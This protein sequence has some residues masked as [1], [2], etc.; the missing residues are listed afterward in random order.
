LIEEPE[1]HLHA[2]RQLKIM[3]FLQNQSENKGLQILI[4]THSPN[5]ASAIKLNNLVIVKNG[6]AY[7]LTEELTKL[8]KSDYEFLERFLD[9]TK[10]NLF[11]A[12]GLMIV[13]GDA[14]NLLIPTLASLLNL[15][16]TDNGVS[17]VN[18]GGVGLSRYAR[19]FQ[20]IDEDNPLDI[21][22]ACVTDSDVMPN[23]AI[24]ILGLSKE[25]EDWHQIPNRK[26]RVL[27]D[28]GEDHLL[29]DYLKAKREKVTGQ[30]VRSFLSNN[31]TFEYDLILGQVDEN[32][33]YKMGLAKDVFTAI[34]LAKNDEK[35][36][37]GSKKIEDVQDEIESEFNLLVAEK[38]P[39]NTSTKEEVIA[40]EIY[41]PLKNKTVSKAV[42]AQYLANI[43]SRKYF[44]GEINVEW[45]K[46]NLPEYLLS[47]IEYVTSTS[48]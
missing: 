10:A 48:N 20:R 11:F 42:V 40:T 35:I 23:C 39:S 26:W 7:A 28:F 13:E 45:L 2:Q 19:I 17:I 46:E 31:W 33:V 36:T 30:S 5:L 47:S 18:V 29:K 32:G 14:E 1:A 43:L 16:F 24:E 9:V 44:D 37:E 41:L 3:K 38:K 27:D 21:P 12:K 25:G 22:V 4:T 34:Q 8:T 6:K 15:D